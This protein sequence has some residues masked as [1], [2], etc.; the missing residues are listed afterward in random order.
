MANNKDFIVKNDIEATN[1]IEGLGTVG[2]NVT[3]PSG[4][5]STTLYT[6]N[7]GTQSI[8][9]G[10]DLSGGNEGLVWIKGRDSGG[11]SHHLFDTVRGA[12]KYIKSDT[13]NAEQTDSNM[14]TGFTSTGFNLGSTAATNSN[15]Y[16]FVSWTWK[17]AANY[18]DVV[19]YT[20]NGSAGR[21]ISHNLGSAP[22]MVV[23]KGVSDSSDWSVFHRSVGNA[24]YMA[25]NENSAEQSDSTRFQSTTPTSTQFTVGSGNAVNGSGRTY[26]AYLFA[27]NTDTISCGEYSGNGSATGPTVDIGFEPQW[28]MVKRKDS[29]DGWA[30]VDSQR[31]FDTSGSVNV[32]RINDNGAD[33]AAT[34]VKTNSS[35]FQ[36][37]T[38]DNEWNNS[39]GT[40]IYMAVKK[41]VNESV[42]DLST[43]SVFNFTPTS[44]TQ[45]TLTNPAPS[46]T[47]SQATLLYTSADTAG[48]AD[49]FS[50]DTYSGNDTTNQI[51]NG[52]N[53]SGDGGLIWLKSTSH[54]G[55]NMVFDTARGISKNLQPSASAGEDT[56]SAGTGLISFNSD[57]FTLGAGNYG[58]TNDVGKEFLSFSWKKASGFFD[59]VTYTGN[60]TAGR[61]IAH[62]LGSVPGFIWVKR[63]G[64]DNW[65]C[66]HRG[67][68]G[69]SSPEDYTLYLNT[70]EAQVNQDL[71]ADTAP[72]SSVFSV[73]D[74][75]KVNGGAS[76]NYIAYLFGHSDSGPI[77]CGFYTGNGS[78]Q[79]IN[80]G[81]E[82]QWLMIKRVEDAG[83][84]WE[85][86]NS[87]RGYGA[88]NDK[89]I[90]ANSSVAEI[91]SYNYGAFTST[92]F[93]LTND[94]SVNASSK[95]YIYMAIAAEGATTTTYNNTIDWPG[96]TAPTSPAIGET[97]VLTF[98]TSDGGATYKAVHAIDGA[99]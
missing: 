59:I 62:N 51:T 99:K 54:T 31:G 25:W 32:L 84:S 92:G 93:D 55:S 87:Q 36:I 15:T 4:S 98:S 58:V 76:N 22:G 26:V 82:P 16:N 74:N 64:N 33:A 96:G 52:V 66:Y 75:V 21:A 20:G 35:G 9:T 19:T 18:F 91:T 14:L 69:G 57:G 45:V 94:N 79:S 3:T 46:G 44:N 43:G 78:T 95:K 85:I 42:L 34:R 12:T 56:F 65:T 50:V 97:D 24:K 7:G 49:R 63:L 73:G 29:A 88:G 60:G 77:Q 39:S 28:L 11:F 23:I 8:A 89:V 53:L 86:V 10:V 6:G 70:D 48:I 68:N 17:S 2:A 40:Y 41:A 80:V 67:A 71:W 81:F 83:Y 30:I 37:V 61:T 47:V 13:T 5:F 90:R 72:T 27:H 38:T 1:I